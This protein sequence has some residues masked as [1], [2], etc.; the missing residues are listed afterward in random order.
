M[1]KVKV[2]TRVQVLVEVTGGPWG[3]DASF[4]AVAKIAKQEAVAKLELVLMREGGVRVVGAPKATI[5]LL[6]E[7]D[8]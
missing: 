1:A 4:D 2:T 7:E 8:R 6:D 5:V 3:G